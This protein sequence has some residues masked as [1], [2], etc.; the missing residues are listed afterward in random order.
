[1]WIG[2]ELVEADVVEKQRARE[3]YETIKHEKKD[4]GLLEWSGGNI[5]K[6]SVFPIPPRSEKRI[7]ISYTQVLP[8]RGNSYRYGYA[9]QSELLKLNPLRELS[10]DVK[11]SS[12]VPLK[13]ISSPTH[14]V[15]TDKTAYAAHVEFAAQEYTPTRDFEVV[16]ETEGKQAEVVVIPHRRGEDGYFMLQLTPPSTG[17]WQ[18]E[19]LPDG[20]P[21]QVLIL[22]DTSA[23]MDAGQRKRQADVVAGL[24]TALTPRDAINLAGCDVDCDWVFE[25]PVA[26]EPKN[27]AAARAFL[28]QRQSLGWTNLDGAFAA[29]FKQAGPKTHIV[30]IGDGIVTTG[31]ARPNGFAQRVKEAYREAA[32]TCHAVAVGSSFEPAVLKA[33][34]SLGSGSLRRVAGEERPATVATALLR[35][36]SQPGLRDVKIEFRG[37]ET[38]RVY[39]EELANIPA[40]TQQILLGLYSPTGSD[41]S[42]EVVVTA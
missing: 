36:M 31:D 2:D 1:M 12:A 33:I 35:E 25:N 10:I 27:L 5:F 29:A 3:I 23:S 21:L 15:R 11:I 13:N 37:L 14:T 26:A 18:R 22:A 42:G 16:V 28:D 30:Y 32:G 41:Q 39:P 6:A 24:F 4:P 34:A 20:E 40:G 38:A 9:L 7:K 19:I 17:E 8:A